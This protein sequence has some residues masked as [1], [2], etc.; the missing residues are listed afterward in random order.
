MVQ[1]EVCYDYVDGIVG[2]WQIWQFCID[3]VDL[4]MVV[5]C[6]CLYGGF[7]FV[8]LDV[9]FC[10]GLGCSEFFVV[11]F[12]VEQVV[13]VWC[14][15]CVLYC[16]QGFGI[17]CGVGGGICFVDVG[18]VFYQV[19]ECVSG[20]SVMIVMIRMKVVMLSFVYWKFVSIM[21]VSIDFVVVDKFISELL[22]FCL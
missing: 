15:E 8:C 21:L 6:Y 3:Y 9:L 22:W 19:W 14:F 4:W 17:E 18:L 1:Y 2:E 12:D 13:F 20:D 16:G 7:W 10:V 11:G 5:M